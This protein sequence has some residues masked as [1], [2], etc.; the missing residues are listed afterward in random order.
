MNVFVVITVAMTMLLRDFGPYA[1][2]VYV[3]WLVIICC[4]GILAR[5]G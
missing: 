2:L 4:E 1:L 5:M 3:G